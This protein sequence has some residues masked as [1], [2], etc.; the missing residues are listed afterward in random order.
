MSTCTICY[1]EFEKTE[2]RKVDF[3]CCTKN[4]ECVICNNCLVNIYYNQSEN[5]DF[6]CPLCRQVCYRSSFS[7]FFFDVFICS[8]FYSFLYFF[9]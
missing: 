3:K 7:L 5:D 1:E 2:D 9:I 8:I 4:C 6:K